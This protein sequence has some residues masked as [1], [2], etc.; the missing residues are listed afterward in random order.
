M[1][2]SP[3]LDI[4][5]VTIAKIMS[6]SIS[7]PILIKHDESKETIK[8]LGLL[9]SGAGGEFIDQNYAKKAGFEIKKLDK[10]LRALNVDG[11][12]NKRGSPFSQRFH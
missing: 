8:T 5:S 1:S 9:D 6:N 11:T 2:I 10:P 12:K 3:V 4:Y 7:V